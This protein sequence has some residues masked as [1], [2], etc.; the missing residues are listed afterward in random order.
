MAKTSML[1]LQSHHMEY[2]Y[3]EPQSHLLNGQLKGCEGESNYPN[4]KN[5]QGKKEMSHLR[6]DQAGAIFSHRH[7]MQ[8]ILTA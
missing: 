3:S 1:A 6:K 7:I 5:L 2:P 4:E 8:D